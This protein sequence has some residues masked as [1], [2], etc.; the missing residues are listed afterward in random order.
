M[1]KF[2]L[3]LALAASVL[4]APAYTNIS[5]NGYRLTT[6][7]S[8]PTFFDH[9]TNYDGED[10]T[11]GSI[12]Y[13]NFD[14]AVEKQLQGWV[15]YEYFNRSHVY[16]G[17]DYR[18]I[19]DHRDSVRVVS[20]ETYGPGTLAVLDVSHIPTGLALWPAV[21]C[22]A[23]GDS[24][25]NDGEMDIL[26]W[27]NED[28]YNSMTLHSGRGCVVDRDPNGYLGTM[29]HANCSTP[30]DN[31]F[32]AEGC[33]TPGPKNYT[34]NGKPFAT[35]GKGF[36]AQ[37]GGV[38]V[39]E[40]TADGVSVWLF[41]RDQLPDDLANGR[42]NPSTW[43]QKPLAKFSGSGCDFTTAF[44]PQNLIINIDLCGQWAGKTFPTPGNWTDCNAY[45][46]GSS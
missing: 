39:H 40:W 33:S 5:S 24:W 27:V 3:F 21:W 32:R 23:P 38:Y 20:K 6:E 4:G 9:F 19:V 46:T 2:V 17:L 22:L 35:A 29:Q 37:G 10:P 36:N 26:E 43:K 15:Y 45:V 18:G 44:Q 42:P 25:G 41:P 31:I 7:Y 8:H 12:N 34:F 14:T 13:V 16:L 30:D 11:L 1:S 28:T